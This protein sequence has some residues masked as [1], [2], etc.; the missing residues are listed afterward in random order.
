MNCGFESLT[1]PHTVTFDVMS[2]SGVFT[3]CTY[4]K[5]LTINDGVTCIPKEAFSYCRA[6][7]SVVFPQNHPIT[8]YERAFMY[9]GFESLTIPSTVTL[10]KGEEPPQSSNSVFVMCPLIYIYIWMVN[11]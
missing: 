9:C 8:L 10:S 4:L 1:I 11:L 3:Q 6:L 5:T 2:S 7:S